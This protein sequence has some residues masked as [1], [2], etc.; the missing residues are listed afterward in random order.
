[1]IVNGGDY[2]VAHILQRLVHVY[3]QR[4]L[5]A[6]VGHKVITT[7]LGRVVIGNLLLN[8]RTLDAR[9]SGQQLVLAGGI[10]Q[11]IADIPCHRQLCVQREYLRIGL[12]ALCH[13][14]AGCRLHVGQEMFALVRGDVFIHITE[15]LFNHPQ[16]FADKLR[17]ADCYL[18]LVLYP[19]LIVDSDDRVQHILSPLDT[20]IFE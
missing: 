6:T 20:Y 2:G 17:C 19:V 18:V 8:S 13:I 12:A 15:F 16:A 14:H 11:V 9:V 5:L 3:Y 10:G 1:M 7:K 4:I